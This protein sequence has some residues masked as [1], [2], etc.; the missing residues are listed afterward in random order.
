MAPPPKAGSIGSTVQLDKWGPNVKL[1]QLKPSP[2]RSTAVKE[3]VC[4]NYELTIGQEGSGVVLT[5]DLDDLNG[6]QELQDFLPLTHVRSLAQDDQGFHVEFSDR[7]DDFGSAVP[8][9]FPLQPGMEEIV[10]AIRTTYGR[11]FIA[12]LGDGEE[13][14]SSQIMFAREMLLA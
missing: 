11:L 9:L 1:R 3:T 10:E 7:E 8:V 4:E 5:F 14:G 13:A 6:L 12:A 2:H